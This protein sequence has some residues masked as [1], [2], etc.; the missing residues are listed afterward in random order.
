MAKWVMAAGPWEAFFGATSPDPSSFSAMQLVLG[1]LVLCVLLAVAFY[2]V[3]SFRDYAAGDRLDPGQLQSNF[4]EMLRRGD[5]TEAEYRMIQS[6][7]N[8]DSIAATSDSAA[9]AGGRDRGRA[10]ASRND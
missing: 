10:G 4:Q 6:K 2:L 8:G 3:S 5:I 7:S 1:V 9:L